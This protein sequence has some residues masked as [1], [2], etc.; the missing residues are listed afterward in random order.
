MPV[1]PVDASLRRRFALNNIVLLL[2]IA[3][4]LVSNVLARLDP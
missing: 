4:Q 1:W 3:M 2:P